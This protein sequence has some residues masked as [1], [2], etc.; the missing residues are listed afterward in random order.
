M[1]TTYPTPEFHLNQIVV[2]RSY[3]SSGAVSLVRGRIVGISE[4]IY[5]NKVEFVYSIQVGDRITRRFGSGLSLP[6][7]WV[8][9][10]HPSPGLFFLRDSIDGIGFMPALSI[11]RSQAERVAAILNEKKEE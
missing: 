9:E 10:E 6:L 11:T 3:P 1:D 7:R 5:L 8:A 4:E 2:A